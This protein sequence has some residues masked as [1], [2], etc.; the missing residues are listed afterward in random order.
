MYYD[1]FF[2]CNFC[3]YYLFNISQQHLV[4]VIMYLTIYIYIYNTIHKL[5]GTI[6]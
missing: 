3:K 5:Y 6:I 1:N 4:R 2:I